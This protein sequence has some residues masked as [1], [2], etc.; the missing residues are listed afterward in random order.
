MLQFLVL[1]G[2]LNSL[3][4]LLFVEGGYIYTSDEF[5]LANLLDWA[6]FN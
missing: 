6:C 1:L 4:P 3:Y 5:E 2:D